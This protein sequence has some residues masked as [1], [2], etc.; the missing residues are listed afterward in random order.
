MTIDRKAALRA[1]VDLAVFFRRVRLDYGL[2]L[3]QLAREA[4]IS[5]SQLHKW[6]AGHHAPKLDSLIRLADALHVRIVIEPGGTVRGE[7]A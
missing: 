1:Q 4:G 3:R 7:P 2:T 5:A 6:E